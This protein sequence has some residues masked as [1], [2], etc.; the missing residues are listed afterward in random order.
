MEFNFKIQKTDVKIYDVDVSIQYEDL[1]KYVDNKHFS[2]SKYLDEYCFDEDTGETNPAK[3]LI[4]E[5][6]HYKNFINEYI[7]SLDLLNLI[8]N[9]HQRYQLENQEC[10]LLQAEEIN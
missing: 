5:K 6:E 4:T 7:E 3:S 2:F 8:P 9:T 10:I 1:V